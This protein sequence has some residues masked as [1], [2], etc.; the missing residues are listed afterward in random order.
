M[1]IEI[2]VKR[3][4]GNIETTI[5]EKFGSFNQA[6]WEKMITATKNAGRGECLSYREIKKERTF[7]PSEKIQCSCCGAWSLIS[8]MVG[9][10]DKKGVYDY[11]HRGCTE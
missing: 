10:K 5:T 7:D 11:Y 4:N 2:T 3:P 6:I 8:D 9:I 1:K